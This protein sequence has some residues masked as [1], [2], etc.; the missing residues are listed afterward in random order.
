MLREGRIVAERR[1]IDTSEEELIMLANG[2]G[3]VAQLGAGQDRG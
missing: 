1:P 3:A 2:I